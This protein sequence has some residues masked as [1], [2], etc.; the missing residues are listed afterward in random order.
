[1]P[2]LVINRE[3]EMKWNG[4]KMRAINDK[5]ATKT[6]K[7]NEIDFISHTCELKI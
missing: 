6:K 1:M 5:K 2:R 7:K 3:N 4:M